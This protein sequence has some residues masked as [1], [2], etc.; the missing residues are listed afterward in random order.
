MKG[1][2]TDV[3]TDVL[4]LHGGH[5]G[6]EGGPSHA[7]RS[8]PKARLHGRAAEGAWAT[9]AWAAP[10][11][12]CRRAWL[13]S[14]RAWCCAGRRLASSA[15]GA[16]ASAWLQRLW[17]WACR[18]G[19]QGA[20]CGGPA[21]WR[22]TYFSEGGRKCKPQATRGITNRCVLYFLRVYPV[23]KQFTEIRPL[24]ILGQCSPTPCRYGWWM[25]APLPIPPPPQPDHEHHKQVQPAGPRGAAAAVGRGGAAHAAH[26]KDAGDDWVCRCVRHPI[27]LRANRGM[28][29]IKEA[30]CVKLARSVFG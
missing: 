3:H 20:W 14:P 12:A 23:S 17:G 13:V 22:P 30:A 5:I 8:T 27:H 10:S 2:T 15:W 26:A 4:D 21:G 25:S 7:R 18:W 1:A 28:E 29:G 24:S 6:W 19:Q 9:G 16:W 11:L